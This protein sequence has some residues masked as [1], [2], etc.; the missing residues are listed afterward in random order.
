MKKN[1]KH[2]E[3]GMETAEL[4]FFKGNHV[5]DN[6]SMS[7]SFGILTPVAAWHLETLMLAV[8]SML[9]L[10][11]ENPNEATLPITLILTESNLDFLGVEEIKVSILEVHILGDV[12]MT[13]VHV[14][15][16]N[17]GQKVYLSFRSVLSAI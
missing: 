12:F 11:V 16:T 15:T 17:F 1:W 9:Q 6:S 5:Q 3:L 2:F 4:N 13:L 8:M 7:K 14:T 10:P